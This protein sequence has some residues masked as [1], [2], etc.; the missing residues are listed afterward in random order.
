VYDR[1]NQ[2]ADNVEKRQVYDRSFRCHNMRAK[3]FT[4]EATIS[5]DTRKPQAKY[6]FEL[7]STN[8]L[9]R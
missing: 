7:F 3:S 6:F 8:S 9:D 1:G 2:R 5:L 4:S